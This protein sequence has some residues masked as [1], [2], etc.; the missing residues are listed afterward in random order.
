MD[1]IEELEGR[2]HFVGLKMPHQVP[3]R[4]GRQTM[5]RRYFLARLLHP[6]LA[7]GRHARLD[8]PANPFDVDGLR[9]PD[10]VHVLRAAPGAFRRPGDPLT[11]LP[12]IALLTVVAIAACLL[13]VRR[14][15]RLD[16]IASLRFD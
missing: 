1:N 8:R 2:L 11:L 13:P 12:V 4:S 6:V 10:E 15:A 14:A 16:P 5:K 7:K 3:G 9:D